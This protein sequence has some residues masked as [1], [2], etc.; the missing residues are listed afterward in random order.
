MSSNTTPPSAQAELVRH[1]G[2]I[3]E[4]LDHTDVPPSLGFVTVLQACLATLA[5]KYPGPSLAAAGY[6]AKYLLESPERMQR[7]RWSVAPHVMSEEE[8]YDALAKLCEAHRGE[9]T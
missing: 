2:E 3:M 9:K 4:I 1:M 5:V 6:L 7:M 8:A